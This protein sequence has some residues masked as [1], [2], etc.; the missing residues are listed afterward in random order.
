MVKVKRADFFKN[1]NIQGSFATTKE[2]GF[3]GT[4]LPFDFIKGNLTTYPEMDVNIRS[5]LKKTLLEYITTNLASQIPENKLKKIM[6]DLQ[7]N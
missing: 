2:E 4:V 1:G 3:P 6:L 7:K 5:G